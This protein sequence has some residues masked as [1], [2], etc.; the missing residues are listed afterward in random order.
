MQKEV[1]VVAD[2]Q[3]TDA[4]QNISLHV[5]LWPRLKKKVKNEPNELIQSL[6]SHHVL[7]ILESFV[8]T[9]L[10]NSQWWRFCKIHPLSC[11]HRMQ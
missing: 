5:F 1:Q 7:Y 3:H 8:K 10:L 9:H 4:E 11:E 2:I 6:L